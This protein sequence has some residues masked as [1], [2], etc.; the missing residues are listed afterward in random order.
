MS[1]AVP[2]SRAEEFARNLLQAAE[3]KAGAIACSDRLPVFTSPS[4]TDFSFPEGLVDDCAAVIEIV[5]KHSR[6]CDFMRKGDTHEPQDIEGEMKR[7]GHK[8]R[9]VFERLSESK[10]AA[11]RSLYCECNRAHSDFASVHGKMADFGEMLTWVSHGPHC[12][13]TAELTKPYVPIGWRWN[14][15]GTSEVQE[16]PSF[17]QALV[18]WAGREFEKAKP[19]RSRRQLLSAVYDRLAARKADS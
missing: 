7:L 16:L 8:A 11:I 6:A 17:P 1:V 12:R 15:P 2:I 19:A 3:A 18:E 9:K 13:Y 14:P 5:L 4:F 10:Q